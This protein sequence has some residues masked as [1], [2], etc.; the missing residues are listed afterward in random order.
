MR[1]LSVV[2]AYPMCQAYLEVPSQEH[3][4]PLLC[5]GTLLSSS[6]RVLG[7]ACAVLRWRAWC[8]SES[9]CAE[10]AAGLVAVPPWTL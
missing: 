6:A 10:S 2:L 4:A 1:A 5:P 8:S 7:H 3:T 9:S